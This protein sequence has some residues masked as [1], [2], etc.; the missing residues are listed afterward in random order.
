MK[1][2]VNGQEV[3]VGLRLPGP[4]LAPQFAVVAVCDAVAPDSWHGEVTLDGVTVLRTGAVASEDQA[5]RDAAKALRDR[6]TAL[7]S[8]RDS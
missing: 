3:V 7:F 4:A 2:Y 8:E 5:S 6:W 1:R